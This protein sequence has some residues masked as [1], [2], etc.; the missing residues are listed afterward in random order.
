VAYLYYINNYINIINYEKPKKQFLDVVEGIINKNEYVTNHLNFGPVQIKTHNGLI[1]DNIEGETAHIFERNDVFTAPKEGYDILTSYVFW[2]KNTMNY[3]ERDY[4]RIQDVISNI[5]GIYQFITILAIYINTLYNNYI[6]LSDTETLLSSSIHTEKTI[7]IKKEI[8]RIRHIKKNLKELNNNISN[9]M[10]YS[11]EKPNNKNIKSTAIGNN[12]SK[13]N[14]SICNTNSDNININHNHIDTKKI[15][16]LQK[17]NNRPEREKEKNFFSFLL[18][19]CSCEKKENIFKI[20]HEFRIKMISEEHLIKNHLNIYNL[21]R[22]TE[23]KRFHSRKNSYK[24][25]DLIN[26]I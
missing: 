2:L 10:N 3:H 19:K 1:F 25:N 18:F 11:N 4:K 9:N 22:V 12:L 14:N 5:G 20:Y 15:K 16:N 17:Y 24:L 26:L 7:S 6:V 23:R 21:L 8:D 13:S